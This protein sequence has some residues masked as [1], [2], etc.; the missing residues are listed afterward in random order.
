[1]RN[2][3]LILSLGCLSAGC[4]RSTQFQC[5]SNEQC[6]GNGAR[7]EPGVGFCSFPDPGCSSGFKFGEASGSLSNTC[8]GG[9]VPGDGG[10]DDGAPD[11]DAPPAGCPADYITLPNTLA[12][13]RYK[14][15]TTERNWNAAK[16]DCEA[17]AP[18]SAYL[19]IPDELSELQSMNTQGAALRYWVG[20]TDAATEGTFLNVKGMPQAFLPFDT[21]NGEPDDG[22][23]GNTQDCVSR[24]ESTDLIA[25]DKCNLAFA[26]IC[27]CEVP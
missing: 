3:W 15:V 20:I 11:I 8:V 18:G 16:A 24:I 4:L 27:E 7:C 12:D 26:Y 22:N 17:S 10:V 2:A 14:L 23:G 13:H 5:E 25:T 6:G 9:D 19:A 1:M 21:A